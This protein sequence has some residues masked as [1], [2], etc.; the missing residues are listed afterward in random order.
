MGFVETPSTSGIALYD[1]LM[2]LN[3]DIAKFQSQKNAFG[4][5]PRHSQVS[6]NAFG[7][8]PRHSQVSISRIR[9]CKEYAQQIQG[10]V[11]ESL[12]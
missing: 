3:L 4:I 8:E 5:E 1:Q 2:A 9:R 7:I 11:C 6:E 12:S 10:P